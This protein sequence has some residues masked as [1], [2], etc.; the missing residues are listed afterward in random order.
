MK[1]L[2]IVRPDIN[3]NF[4]GVRRIAYVIS[5]L[6]TMVGLA[7]LIIK[8][9][10][11]YGIDFL[12]GTV[13]QVKFS[14]TVPSAKVREAA[15]QVGLDD[16]T[17][18]SLGLENREFLIRTSHSHIEGEE[19]KARLL[20]SLGKVAAPAKAE[21]RRVE[22]VGPKVGNDLRQKALF[23]ILYS[24]LFMAIY[25]SGR[26]ELKWV[27]PI[28]MAASLVFFSYLLYNVIGLG[29]SHVV[30]AS[31]ALIL[32]IM[33]ALNLRY[34][35]GAI[36]ALLH[37]VLVVMGIFSLFDLE[38]SLSM[39][40]ALLTIIGYSVH[41]TIIVFDR[42]RENVRRAG[43]VPLEELVNRSINQTLSRTILTSGTV[44]FVLVAFLILGGGVIREFALA[45]FIGVITGTYSSIFVASPILLA[46]PRK[47]QAGGRWQPAAVASGGAAPA[48]VEEAPVAQEG[49]AP[50]PDRRKKKYRVKK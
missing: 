14:Q 7:S 12:G 37:D 13:V 19:L 45:M 32:L 35:M 29:L 23:A 33:V 5:A 44:L 2:Q 46:W 48:A 27:P 16:A 49:P 25:I 8:G 30:M 11:N 47:K 26:F 36:V 9:G 41:D 1:F 42:I 38:V 40:A 20:N 28:V 10:P 39:V 50:A 17:V 15:G 21:V 24:L 43:R 4:V 22:M 18:Q 6:I 3:I 31:F 34:A